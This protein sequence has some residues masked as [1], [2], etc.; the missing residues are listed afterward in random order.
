MLA[1]LIAMALV[2]TIASP[3]R[4]ETPEVSSGRGVY[5]LPINCSE[6][7]PDESPF[8]QFFEAA[9]RGSAARNKALAK[10]MFRV[11]EMR[12]RFLKN[13]DLSRD[14]NPVDVLIRKTLCYYRQQKEP[15]RPVSY[16]DQGF[17]AFLSGAIRELEGKVE[18]ALFLAL[19]EREQR[20]AY[21]RE[22][23]R[24]RSL[25]ES[26]RREASREA[27]RAFDKIVTNAKRK[28]KAQ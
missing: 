2:M 18:D 16:E 24:N 23:Q 12:E 1:R 20:L 19:L 17:L 5:L 8:V 3:A 13:P 28:A 4:A 6:L 10:R 26:V 14:E 27:E 11:L 9:A 22:L 15:L 25:I 7:L 21:E